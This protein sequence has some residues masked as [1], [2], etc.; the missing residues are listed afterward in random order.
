MQRTQR[1]ISFP[2]LS[3]Q[4]FSL[5]P[6]RLCGE[7]SFGCGRS[8]ASKNSGQRLPIQGALFLKSE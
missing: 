6:L 2:F 5:R 8:S 1:R 7:A 4:N 3:K